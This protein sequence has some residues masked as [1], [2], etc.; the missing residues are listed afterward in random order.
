MMAAHG[1]DVF[2]VNDP[3][4]DFISGGFS[5]PPFAVPTEGAPP[6]DPQSQQAWGNNVWTRWGFGTGY[7]QPYP[8]TRFPTNFFDDFA[9]NYPY[10]KDSN[11]DYSAVIV[12]LLDQ[13]GRSV[14]MA[15]SAGG[16]KAVTAAKT[17][18]EKVYGFI[19]VEPTGPPDEGDFPALAGMSMLGVYGDYIESRNQAGRKAGTEAAAVLFG[20][21]GGTGE[22]ISLPEDLSIFGNTHLMMQD[23]NNIFVLGL[24]INWLDIMEF[25]DEMFE[26]SFEST[27]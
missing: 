16:P 17:R 20:Q 12:T 15:H 1:Y 23:N 4:F 8:N 19:L 13:I 18:P 25:S 22:V 5:V 6:A 14:L 10:V 11:S 21:N 2:I 3:D 24:I 27:D 7:G 26:S 9:D